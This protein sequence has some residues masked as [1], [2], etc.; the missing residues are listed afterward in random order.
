MPMREARRP[1]C[2][3]VVKG[4]RFNNCAAVAAIQVD[5]LDRAVAGEEVRLGAFCAPGSRLPMLVQWTWPRCESTTIPSGASSTSLTTVRTRDPS[6]VTV[7]IN[8]LATLRTRSS[9]MIEC[10]SQD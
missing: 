7:C 1:S 2:L 6:S 3:L 10:A 4:P 8:R 9:V 5:P